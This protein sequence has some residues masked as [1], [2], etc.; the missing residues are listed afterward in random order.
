MNRTLATLTLLAASSQ[1]LAI[2]CAEFS[3]MA[4]ALMR[5]HQSGV[6]MTE[7][8]E[9]FDYI[10]DEAALK[11]IKTMIIMAY[12]KPRYSTE[13][14]QQREIADFRDKFAAACYRRKQ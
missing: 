8:I 9:V 14:M 7:T 10:E 13:K 12:E 11:A 3:R 4:E 1:A 5:S 6:P 2:D